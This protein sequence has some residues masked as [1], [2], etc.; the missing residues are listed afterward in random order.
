MKGL[1]KVHA[2]ASWDYFIP[3]DVHVIAKSASDLS[4]EV[5]SCMW[6]HPRW[7]FWYYNDRAMVDFVAGEYPQLLP[8]FLMLKRPVE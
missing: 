4:K 5:A 7:R 2:E 1:G 8:S 6:H 3:R